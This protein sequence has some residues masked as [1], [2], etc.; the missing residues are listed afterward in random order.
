MKEQNKLY[1]DNFDYFVTTHG[2]IMDLVQYCHNYNI[3]DSTRE[4][5]PK[6]GTKSIPNCF[7]YVNRGSYHINAHSFAKYWAD[8]GVMWGKDID[9]FKKL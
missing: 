5:D 9:E 3:S 1:N 6:D 8:K 2:F 7:Q 4:K